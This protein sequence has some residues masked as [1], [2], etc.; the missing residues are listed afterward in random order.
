MKTK[1]GTES[2]EDKL[3]AQ[4]AVSSEAYKGEGEDSFCCSR[5]GDAALIGVFDGCGGLGARQYKKYDNHTG[6]YMAS[7]LACGAVYDWFQT[8]KAGQDS[9]DALNELKKRIDSALQ[10]GQQ[11]AGDTLK[12]RGTM[13]RDFPTTAAIALAEY[14]EEKISID[15][16]WAGD[17]R[18]YLLD[19]VGLS[20]LS[21]DD[22]G[23]S[24]AFDDLRNDPVQ[25]NVLSSDGNYVLHCRT[26]TIKG[27]VAIIASSDG[28]F[29]YW[30]TPMEFEYFLL[31]TLERSFSLTEW[32]N[33]LHTE[34]LEIAGDD[35][36]LAVML[37]NFRTFCE[38]KSTYHAR[39]EYLKEMYILPL[40][41]S[42]SEEKAKE[43]WQE[44]R[45]TYERYKY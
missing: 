31:D 19:H 1:K 26:A 13:V 28:Y 21:K 11:M 17:S 39:H 8:R 16:I 15:A 37:F 12:L 14:R 29:G 5:S 10:L 30:R 36:T 41:D 40:S 25:E 7:R 33:K 43:L 35:A 2:F 42:Y 44:Y 20:P 34:I 38:L 45:H 23:S 6:A 24:D 27:P 22:T 18:I 9:R 3:A 4:F 32:K